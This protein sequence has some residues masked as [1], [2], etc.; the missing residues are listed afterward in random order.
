MSTVVTADIIGSRELW[1]RAEAQRIL[2]DAV[3]RV[4]AESSGVVRPLTPTVG[5]ELQGVYRDLPSALR[6]ILLLRL[7]LPDGLDIRF[8][9]GLGEIESIRS[10]TGG[11]AEGPGWWAARKAIDTLHAKQV[12]A[13]P[14]ARTWIVASGEDERDAAF[15]NAYSWARD[16]LVSAMS[17]RTRRLVYGRCLGRTQRELAASEGITQSAVSQALT[18]AGAAAVVEGLRELSGGR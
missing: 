1:D 17:E 8:G 9:V 13:M 2:D 6:V 7:A 16:E 14:G 11:I 15:A 10:A 4:H 3:A 12:R 5:D 18:S